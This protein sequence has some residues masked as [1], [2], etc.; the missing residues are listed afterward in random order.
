MKGIFNTDL[1]WLTPLASPFFGL[2]LMHK[3]RN[4]IVSR[5]ILDAYKGLDLWLLKLFLKYKVLNMEVVR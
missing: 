4:A 3:A 1:N 2:V 5:E